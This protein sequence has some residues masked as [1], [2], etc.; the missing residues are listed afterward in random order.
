MSCPIRIDVVSRAW[1]RALTAACALL[2]LAA[3]LQVAEAGTQRNPPE[4]IPVGWVILAPYLEMSYT[5]DD[6]VFRRSESIDIESDQIS[7]LTAGVV[8]RLPVRRS[9]F[10]VD[11]EF[12][13]L[14]YQNRSFTRDID[15][16]G[17]FSFAFEFGTGDRLLLRDRLVRSFS[18]L[19]NVDEGGELIFEGTPYNLNS[20]EVQLSR[21]VRDRKGYLIGGR[22]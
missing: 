22:T 1:R 8:A 20:W 11:L 21:S 3:G 16:E 17:L 13:R 5:A 18:N 14:D 12:S 10:E 9:L 7:T 19:A 2:L 4:G 15:A 6:N